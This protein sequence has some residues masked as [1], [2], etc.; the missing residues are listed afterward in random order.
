[1]ARWYFCMAVVGALYI[2]DDRAPIV[3]SIPTKSEL[4]IMWKTIRNK[5]K[6]GLVAFWSQTLWFV[7][8]MVVGFMLLA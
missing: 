4:K 3:P 7:I 6:E 2:I 1:M 8:G 5:I